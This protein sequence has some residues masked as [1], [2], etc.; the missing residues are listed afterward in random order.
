MDPG[1]ESRLNESPQTARLGRGLDHE[2][3]QAHSGADH[4]QAKDRQ[5]ADHPRQVHR[6]RFCVIEVKQPT[7]HRWRK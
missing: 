5:A 7:Y 2:T 4:P 3:H 1:N 6:R